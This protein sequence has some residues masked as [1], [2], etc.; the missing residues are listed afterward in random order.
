MSR[1][2]ELVREPEQAIASLELTGPN[3]VEITVEAW[4]WIHGINEGYAAACRQR[5]DQVRLQ[6][7]EEFA[8]ILLRE[9]GYRV[10]KVKR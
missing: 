3:A 8:V 9:R 10:E 6:E 7:L 5:M 2:V 1:T 4:V